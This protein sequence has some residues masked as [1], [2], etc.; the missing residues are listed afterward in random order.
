MP[1]WSPNHHW[2]GRS[3]GRQCTLKQRQGHGILARIGRQRGAASGTAIFNLN[4]GW[5]ILEVVFPDRY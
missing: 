1:S 3:L 5:A 4:H 2:G